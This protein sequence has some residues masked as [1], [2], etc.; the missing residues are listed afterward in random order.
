[1]MVKHP[2]YVRERNKIGPRVQHAG[3]E[4]LPTGLKEGRFPC[5]Y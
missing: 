1:M 5:P 2:G 3:R 4:D